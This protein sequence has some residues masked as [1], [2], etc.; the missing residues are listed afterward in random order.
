MLVCRE[1]CKCS[2]HGWLALRSFIHSYIHTF[3]H[4]YIHTF[5]QL[6][7]G[8]LVSFIKYNNFMMEWQHLHRTSCLHI[9]ILSLQYHYSQNAVLG[10]IVLVL[11]VLTLTSH[12]VM[13]NF[14]QGSIQLQER[15]SGGSGAWSPS[16]SPLDRLQRLPMQL[17]QSLPLQLPKKAA[18]R[19]QTKRGKRRFLV[20]SRHLLMSRLQLNSW[21]CALSL[22]GSGT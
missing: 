8:K 2:S 17:L 22:D 19:Q 9:R 14:S 20:L 5:I 16:M 13:I 18:R 4:S 11:S 3:I 15:L 21:R 1:S 6:Y 10:G 7:T 12:Y